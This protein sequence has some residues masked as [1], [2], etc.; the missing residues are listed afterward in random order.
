MKK[1][2]V[3]LLAFIFMFPA[4]AANNPKKPSKPTNQIVTDSRGFFK[5]RISNGIITNEKGYFVG[6]VK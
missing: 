3:F 2:L 4:M 5:G 1:F 6:R